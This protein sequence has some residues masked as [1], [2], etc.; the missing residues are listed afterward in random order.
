MPTRLCSR[1]AALAKKAPSVTSEAD[2]VSER[3][4]RS[5]QNTYGTQM[6]ARMALLR[7]ARNLVT[8]KLESVRL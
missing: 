7:K 1:S 8:S 5:P 2:T 6:V 3:V 4:G